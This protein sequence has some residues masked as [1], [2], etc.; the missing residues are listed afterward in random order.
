MQKTLFLLTMGALITSVSAAELN[1]VKT[2]QGR[3]GDAVTRQTSTTNVYKSGN[4][5]AGFSSTTT[6]TG[7]TTTAGGGKFIPDGSRG[8][9]ATTT[10]GPSLTWTFK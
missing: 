5:Q 3:P 9:T 2:E 7:G 6:V 10:Y 1:T 8:S 4:F